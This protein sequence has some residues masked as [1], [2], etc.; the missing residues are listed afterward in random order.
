MEDNIKWTILKVLLW[1]ILALVISICIAY[2][3]VND[4]K[5]ALRIGFI[6]NL[7]KIIVHYIFERTWIYWRKN[8]ST[9]NRESD[10]EIPDS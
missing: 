8:K 2:F 4:L 5:S 3:I 1:R 9:E 7:I 10:D 6:D